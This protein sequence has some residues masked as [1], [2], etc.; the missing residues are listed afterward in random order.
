MH[1][2]RRALCLI[3]AAFAGTASAQVDLRAV[4]EPEQFDR[5]R[6]SLGVRSLHIESPFAKSSPARILDLAPGK[7]ATEPVIVTLT[8]RVIVKANNATITNLRD[9]GYTIANA[10]AGYTIIVTPSVRAAARLADQLAINASVSSASVEARQSFGPRTPLNDE[11]FDLAWHLH[12]TDQVGNDINAEAAWNLG[13]TGAGVNIG[14]IDQGVWSFHPDLSAQRNNTAGQSGSSSFHGTAVAGVACAIGNNEEGAAGLAHGSTHSQLFYSPQGDPAVNA[15]AFEHRNDLN[16]IKNNSWGPNDTG[17]LWDIAQLEYDALKDSV[18]TGRD[19]KGVIHAWAAGNGGANDR[20]EYDPFAASPY[21]ISIGAIG[22]NALR[23]SYS[24]RGSSLFAVTYS[25]GNG[26]NIFTTSNSSSAPYTSNF[27]G[28]SSACPLAAGALALCLEA[29]PELTWRDAQ[30]LVV[31]SAKPVDTEDNDWTT[32]GA[33]HD[34]NHN[35]GFGQ[36]DAALMVQAAETWQPVAPLT[37]FDAGFLEPNAAI[38][39]NDPAGIQFDFE[40]AHN[41][42]IEHVALDVVA[43]GTYIGD[44]IITLTSP[45]GTESLLHVNRNYSADD[46]DHTFYSVR[47]WD[48]RTAGTWTVSIADAAAQDTHTLSRLALRF[49]GT[50]IAC[51]AD[52]DG[53]FLLT[54]LDLDAWIDN[55]TKGDIKADMNSNGTLEPADFT[56]WIRAFNEGCDL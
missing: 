9:Q 45:D 48:E 31:N 23:S 3:L 27:G 47:H 19:G 12:N 20:V 10:P 13:Y 4:P 44:L 56:A 54:T 40:I 1:P 15:A 51:P 33:G 29:N 26:R 17:H 16:H 24:E 18:I 21:T 38:P 30:H 11:F 8:S 22:N 25:D 39:D 35:Y 52:Q 34:I 41:M 37:E 2:R 49:M 7:P 5:I 28:T 46:M 53:D 32:N 6:S 43:T 55:Y 36:L 50:D 14:I 42:V